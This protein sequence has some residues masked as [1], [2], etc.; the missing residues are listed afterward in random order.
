MTNVPETPHLMVDRLAEA[1][2]LITLNRPQRLNALTVEMVGNLNEILDAIATDSA[3]RAVILTGSGRGFCSGQDVVAADERNRSQPT[4]VVERM[5]RQ[6]QFAG[7]GERLRNLPQVVIAAVNGPCAGVGLALA[8]AADIRIAAR[9]ARFLIASMRL[10]LTAGESGI[11]YSLPRLLGASRAFEIMLTGRPVEAPEA[12]RIGLCAQLVED[13]AAVDAALVIAK[14]ILSNSP[15]SIT[16]TKRLMWQNL[17]AT[18]FRAAIELENRSQI[19][20]SLT[21]DYK[22]A[23]AAFSQKRTPRFRGQ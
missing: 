15:F 14:T 3:C 8:L 2:T 23:T 21:D 22:E 13:G 11:S 17:D 12:E 6:E 20:A 16:H 10:G 19:L 4:G 5:H 18:G 1:V 7:M 9:S